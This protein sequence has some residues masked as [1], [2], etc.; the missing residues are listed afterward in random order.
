VSVCVCVC[1]CVC[2]DKVSLGN[3]SLPWPRSH[4]DMLVF[5]FQLLRLKVYATSTLA[6]TENF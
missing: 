5:A 2:V 6:P 1:V 3:P 4:R